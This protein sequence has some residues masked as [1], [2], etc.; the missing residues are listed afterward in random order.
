MSRVIEFLERVAQAG[1]DQGIAAAIDLGWDSPDAAADDV[2]AAR[3][4]A[5]AI[6]FVGYVSAPD[7]E[8]EPGEVPDDLPDDPGQDSEAA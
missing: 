3:R 2:R 6:A 7:Q 5:S 1:D 8:P 4:A